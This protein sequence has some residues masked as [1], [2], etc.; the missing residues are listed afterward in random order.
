MQ[1]F[2]L[3]EIE[4]SNSGFSAYYRINSGVN[5]SLEL[6]YFIPLINCLNFFFLI[7][8]WGNYEV[9]FLLIQPA[10]FIKLSPCCF[11]TFIFFG[12]TDWFPK[13]FTF[14]WHIVLLNAAV[15]NSAHLLV[16]VCEADSTGKTKCYGTAAQRGSRRLEAL[17]YFITL[18]PHHSFEAS[19]FRRMIAMRDSSSSGTVVGWLITYVL[20]SPKYCFSGGW[21]HIW[22]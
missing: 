6:L 2:N 22:S 15:R 14:L 9:K 4:F 16:E 12:V 3:N 13:Q 10:L 7:K 21:G 5:I 8:F 1:P 11:L 18:R 19:L 20:L 17:R